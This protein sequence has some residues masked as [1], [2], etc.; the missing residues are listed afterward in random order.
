MNENK[1]KWSLGRKLVL[2]VVILAVLV[3]AGVGGLLLGGKYFTGQETKVRDTWAVDT[4]ELLN[5]DSELNMDVHAA[6]S[7][8]RSL[9]SPTARY[10]R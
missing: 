5:Y 6:S 7:A 1:K 8:V 3:V 4:G 10:L 2:A 9:P